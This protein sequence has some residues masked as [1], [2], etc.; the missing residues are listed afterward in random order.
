MISK[1]LY[2]YLSKFTGLTPLELKKAFVFQLILFLLITT[3]LVLKPTINSVFISNLG[4]SALPLAYVITALAAVIGFQF[5]AKAIE[6]ISFKKVVIS[7]LLATILIILL[8]AVLFQFNFNASFILYALYAFIAIYGLLTTSQF[9]LIANASYSVAEA[10]RTFG[11]IGAGGIAGG[12][13]GGYLTALLTKII[14]TE[15]IL[16]VAAFLL[17]CTI[18]LYRYL[19]KNNSITTKPKATT[20]NTTT[21]AKSSWQLIKKSKLLTYITITAALS[22]FVA[23]L[24]DYQYSNFASNFTNNKEELGSFFGVWLSNISIISLFI[25]LLLTQKII[26]KLGV[27]NSLLLMPFGILLGSIGFLM[28][29]KLWFPVFTKIVDGS[30]KQSINKSA[31]ELT[32]MPIPQL[33]KQKTKTFI[34]VAVDSIATGFA[35]I[36]LYLIM[37]QFSV[38]ESFINITTILFIVAWIFFL[39]QLKYAYRNSFKTLANFPEQEKLKYQPNTIKK[40][41]ANIKTSNFSNETLYNLVETAAFPINLAANEAL[42][43]KQ[44]QS[45]F[46]VP[47]AFIIKQLNLQA[48]LLKENIGIYNSLLAEKSTMENA[49]NRT[50]ITSILK[51][52]E[53]SQ[54]HTRTLIASLLEL[55]YKVEDIHPILQIINEGEQDRIDNS[56]EF[57]NEMVSIPIRNELSTILN[58]REDFN[59][60]FIQSNAQTLGCKTYSTYT[61]LE[62]LVQRKDAPLVEASLDF[63]SSLNDKLFLPVV[64]ICRTKNKDS[65]ITNKASNLE[66]RLRAN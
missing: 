50:A 58:I 2:S 27:S 1:K 38:S 8:F 3:L 5:Y 49:T 48:H 64:E 47:E 20:S 60:K 37:K 30:F 66:N 15:N 44:K 16:F 4:V 63:I 7:S 57:L 13:F 54:D 40:S 31:K 28:F 18:P 46:K 51:Q 39:F 53:V 22:V 43:E 24:V 62:L 42:I 45:N 26:K 35:G 11:F 61:L 23:K 6:K 34:D 36:M 10:K 25:Q 52:I 55:R 41:I 12:I 29:P 65:K 14:P 32:F 33:V 21:K 17:L 59:P 56:L 19:W 9:W